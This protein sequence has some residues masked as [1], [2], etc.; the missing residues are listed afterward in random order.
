MKK[1]FLFPNQFKIIGWILFIPSLLGGIYFR[2]ADMMDN[3]NDAYNFKV[4]AIISDQIFSKSD[5][6]QFINNNILDELIL[7]FIII[8]GILVAFSKTK[9]ED[10]F[11]SQLRY[12]SLVW[13]VYFNFATILFATFFVYGLPYFDFMTM[14]IFSMLLFYIIRFHFLLYKIQKST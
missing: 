6:F 4:F 2:A 9:I 8:G 7:L 1:D 10:E 11:I 5:F 12:E 13:A 14:N 3:G